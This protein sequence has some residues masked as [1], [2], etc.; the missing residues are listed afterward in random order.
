[1]TSAEFSDF[2]TP[3][4]PYLQVELICSIKF[5]QPPLLRPLFHDPPSMRTSYLEPP[6][7][8]FPVE[9]DFAPLGKLPFPL[10]LSLLWATQVH[11]GAALL[12]FLPSFKTRNNTTIDMANND[13]TE[14]RPQKEESFKGG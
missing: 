11:L 5:T 3:S 6:L 12:L 10:S 7:N 13:A 1:M 14:G 2:L 9:L 4:P 8:S